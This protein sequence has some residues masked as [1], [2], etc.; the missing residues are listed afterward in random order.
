MD[1][2]HRA[3]AILRWIMYATRPLSV[4]ELT[5]ALLIQLDDEHTSYPRDDL[6]DT[7]DDVYVNDQIRRLCGSLIDVKPQNGLTH[8]SSHLVQLVHFSVKEYLTRSLTEQLLWDGEVALSEPLG[9]HAYLTQC[10]LQYLCYDNFNQRTIST[11]KEYDE[12]SREFAFLRYASTQWGVHNS[13]RQSSSPNLIALSNR[14]H[15][16]TNFRWRAY[17]EVLLNEVDNN[18]TQCLIKWKDNWPGPVYLACLTN[19]VQTVEYVLDRGADVNAVG[20]TDATALQRA[21]CGG[22]IESFKLLL[23]RGADPSFRGGFHGSVVNAAAAPTSFLSDHLRLPS[24]AS[25]ERSESMLRMLIPKGVDLESSDRSGQKP[26]HCAS[27]SGKHQFSRNLPC[28]YSASED[29]LSYRRFFLFFWE[30]VKLTS[31]RSPQ[32]CTASR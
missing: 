30:Y 12:R 2:K 4:R 29:G 22:D 6:P 20:G 25:A 23:S 28:R 18:F 7:Y 11:V 19:I 15:D 24:T 17:S 21:A 32:R 27:A 14:L 3:I 8:I 31:H 26:L 5:E 9:N 16:P 13:R 10:C 1:E